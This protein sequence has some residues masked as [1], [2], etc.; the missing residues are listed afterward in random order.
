MIILNLRIYSIANVLQVAKHN[1]K[2][3]NYFDK[4][5]IKALEI[6]Q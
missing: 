6:T 1:I 4:Y 5:P 3:K 2:E